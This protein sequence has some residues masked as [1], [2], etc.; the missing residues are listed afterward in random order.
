[1]PV[2]RDDDRG[3]GLSGG[4]LAHR[5]AGQQEDEGDEAADDVQAVK[6]GG[7]VED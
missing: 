6:S 7:Q 4:E 1:M 2:V 3:S 5:G